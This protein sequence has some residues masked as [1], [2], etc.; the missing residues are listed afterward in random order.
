MYS[1]LRNPFSKVLA[2]VLMVAM[3]FAMLP[4]APASAAAVETVSVQLVQKDGTDKT[5]STWTFD[6]TNQTYTDGNTGAELSIV[7]DYSANPLVYTG[8]N[9]KPDPRCLSVTTKGIALEDLYD[10]AENL[11]G[12]INLRGDTAMYLAQGTF[13][14]N[15]TYDQ[16]WGLTRYN[17][18]N[19][20]NQETYSA[21][22]SDYTDGVEVAG[23]LAIIG[24]HSAVND[25][26]IVTVDSLIGKSD[27]ENALRI[28]L[29][30]QLN[31]N[32][33]IADSWVHTG[34]NRGTGDV[35]EGNLSVKCIDTIKFTPNYKAITVADGTES[36]TEGSADYAVAANNTTVTTAD[37]WFK[38]A[39]DEIVSLTVAADSGYKVKSVAVTKNSDSSN[40]A[41]N[42]ADGKYQFTMPNEA[43][44]VTVATAEID[45]NEVAEVDG[46]YVINT[47]TQ[48]KW[49]ADQVNSGE[50]DF[51]GKTVRLAANID[52][53]GYENWTAIG[54]AD[55]AFAGTFDGNDKTVS[56]LKISNATGGYK[57]LFG[58]NK[59]VIKNLNINGTIGTAD[60]NVTAGSDN[61]GGLV[62]YNNGTVTG[63]MGNVTVYV[64]TNNIYAVGGIV[65]Q[66]G[67]EGRI[68]NC[69]NKADVLGTKSAGGIC[70][71]SYGVVI[72]CY[73]TGNITG[74]GGGKDGIG[75]I[76]G[77]AGDKSGTYKNYITNCYN[78]GTISNNGGRW[79][80]GI[81]GFADKAGV[82]CDCYNIGQ[83]NT[84]Y[85]WNWN[86][87]IGHVDG[88]SLNPV[89]ENNYS[90]EGLNA[91]D[92]TASTQP[93]T[94]GTVK[95]A[96][97]MK[98]A[99]LL[100]LLNR[101]DATFVADSNNLNNG[102]PVLYWQ[103]G[104]S[105]YD[106]T[107]DSNIQ[108]GTVTASETAAEGATV[109]V[110][111]NA[112][113]GYRLGTLK[114]TTDGENYTDITVDGSG[115]YSFVMPAGDVTI[116]ADFE[117]I[118][119]YYVNVKPS[120]AT[121][122]KGSEFNVELVVGTKG[123]ET[124]GG[125]EAVLNYDTNAVTMVRA[126]SEDINTST[127]GQ[128]K[129]AESGSE[130]TIG[131]GYTVLTVTFKAVDDIAI[132][133][134]NAVFS[135]SNA[136]VVA[137]GMPTAIEADC[138]NAQTVILTNYPVSLPAEATDVT[139]VDSNNQYELGNDITFKLA[140]DN[141]I[142]KAQIGNGEAKVLTAANGVYTIPAADVKGAVE[143]TVKSILG[144]VSFIDFNTYNAA[145]TGYKVVKFVPDNANNAVKYQ[146]D[147]K[148]MFKSDKYGGYVFFVTENT[149][150]VA[151]LQA[152]SAVEGSNVSL[153]YDGEVNGNEI[154]R[155]DDAQ[156]VYDLYTNRSE[157]LVDD[158]FQIVSV[159]NRLEADVNGDGT[160]DSADARAIIAII[161]GTA[162]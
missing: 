16:Y 58:N 152:I 76:V 83:I 42:L 65:G 66:N 28:S 101:D 104:L 25:E 43:V 145:P 32:K 52:L 142:V 86:P 137:N 53:S 44:T 155:V 45:P 150:D 80:G 49:V 27:A 133:K 148:D 33:V 72:N 8:L 30:Q 69:G 3:T 121:V 19:W 161:L 82:I 1:A 59:G 84:G 38:A 134:T 57:G 109:S 48:L 140:G 87:I 41:V 79:F 6:S 7:T 120:A 54:N 47:A 107:V 97:E 147:G 156:L 111:A 122:A 162:E 29:G 70:G 22:F 138:G 4:V 12:G 119:D 10:Y 34:N 75:G 91:G 114:Y 144:T 40:V 126:S 31:G 116:T 74:N 39:G 35:N 21:D 73:N 136:M 13:A 92:T 89:A 46:V 50:N 125:V 130:K 26:G 90:L 18:M 158:T 154:I 61:I 117:L 143:V 149:T 17:Y 131:N 102:Y 20:Y 100:E 14:D 15:F 132:G 56:N 99:D 110:K 68:E 5:L 108:N 124:F 112:A 81:A 157:Y 105:L 63:V 94:I 118:P 51:A 88:G 113:D 95:T 159:F 103:N 106:V 71:R 36:G 96:T 146:Y 64:N 55:K 127:A 24:Y 9:K 151:A 153:A 37:N 2:L 85:S 115:N 98:A 123:P 23:T 129:Y 62:G 93:L 11:A 135:V 67:P 128:I 77:L 160:V 141:L 78:T 139:G 60:A